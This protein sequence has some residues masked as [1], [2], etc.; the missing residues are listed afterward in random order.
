MSYC[1]DSHFQNIKAKKEDIKDVSINI[2]IRNIKKIFKEL[3]ETDNP[4]TSLFKDHVTVCE[5]LDKM[6]SEASKKTM[7]VSIVVF[8]KS[9]KR[10]PEKTRKIYSEKLMDIATCQNKEYLK[11][12]KSKKEEKSW[13]SSDDIQKII[14]G[15]EERIKTSES[16]TERQVLDL[17]QRYVVI[18]LYTILPP[19]RNDYAFTKIIRKPK[20]PE[21][22]TDNYFNLKTKKLVL[23]KYKTHKFYGDKT[24]DIPDELVK[25]IDD[26]EKL[27]SK[28]YGDKIQ[29]NY[30]LI[31]TTSLT[32]MTRCGI[33]K[34]MN[35]IFS[36]KKVS[37][38][39]LRKVYLSN[40]YPIQHS[41]KEME[42]DADI[43][44][45]D[46]MTARKIY[47]KIL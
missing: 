22:E 18:K 34:Y 9:C 29:H 6:K 13:V 24:I 31:N 15:L 7:C 25:I 36:P 41:M 5:Y 8:L 2:Y 27:K 28:T 1:Y 35:K 43:M 21:K 37:T 47:T 32:P 4:D 40:K 14:S 26:Y 44:G 12:Q 38:T 17:N 30:L 33:T 39:I 19:V 42:D 45:H 3:F 10:F 46:I 23:K 11:N 20:E 16:L